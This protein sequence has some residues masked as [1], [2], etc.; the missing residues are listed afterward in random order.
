MNVLMGSKEIGDYLLQ[1]GNYSL[2]N[3]QTLLMADPSNFEVAYAINPHMKDENGNLK[4]VDRAK[5]ITQWESLKELYQELG[6]RVLILPTLPEAPDLVFTA[7]SMLPFFE[8]GSQ[9][10]R[11]LP[12]VMFSEFRKAEVKH[13][14][15]FLEGAGYQV[16]SQF[17]GDIMEGNGDVLA[18]P[19]APLF[20]AGY[21]FRTKQKSLQRVSELTGHAVVPLQLVSDQFYHLDTCLSVLSKDT[22]AIVKEAFDEPSLQRIQVLF[23]R[24]IEISNQE[25]IEAFAGNCFCPDGKN[26]VLQAGADEF[27]KKLRDEGFR[28]LPVETS[29]FMKSGG[30]VFCLKLGLH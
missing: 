9:K 16:L 1:F 11:L 3:H 8:P 29:E 2:Q 23:P 21:G 6:I 4:K 14:A 18:F 19:R 28:C 17:D 15:H 10:L 24:I 22:V 13:A 12:S 20:I 5:A 25:A 27:E 30:S 26:V 7:N